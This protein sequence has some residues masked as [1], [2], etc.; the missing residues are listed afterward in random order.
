[1]PSRLI[2]IIDRLTNSTRIYRS[3]AASFLLDASGEL[4]DQFDQIIS[5]Q[6]RENNELRRARPL[7]TYG[8]FQLTLF[9]WSPSAPRQAGAAL[10][11]I[12]T[13]ML[14]HNENTR[15]LLELEY[16]ADGVLIGIHWQRVGVAFLAPQEVERLRAAGTGLRERRLLTAWK[17]RKVGP[18]EQ[19]PCGSGLKYKRC[20][21]P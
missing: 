2:E 4:R 6:L 7:S 10:E 5:Q 3:E 17:Q 18:N 20:C 14:A 9:C 19:C 15:P 13:V 1:M 16:S 12:R 8:D 11:H 21:R